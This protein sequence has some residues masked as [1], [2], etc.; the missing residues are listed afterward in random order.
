MSRND[1]TRDELILA[2]EFYHRC[3]E[4]M[5]TDSHIKCQAVAKE[6]GRTA[7]AL[8]RIIR[9][10][11]FVDTGSIGLG[12]ASQA[13]NNLAFDYRGNV[14]GLLEEASRIR[15][16][17]KLPPAGLRRLSKALLLEIEATNVLRSHSE[18]C[19]MISK[20]NA[21]GL[22]LPRI[23]IYRYGSIDHFRD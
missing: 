19:P 9:N 4:R 8:D 13:I 2:M 5:H 11:K 15:R 10:I 12:H 14:H 6:L 21:S 3:P 7:G 1:W 17:L 20:S 22:C 16:R 23:K 18:L